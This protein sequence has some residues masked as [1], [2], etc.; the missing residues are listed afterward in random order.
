MFI[1]YLG[2]AGLKP[3]AALS[4]VWCGVVAVMGS[5][6]CLRSVFTR[7][8]SISNSTCLLLSTGILMLKGTKGCLVQ[9]PPHTTPHPP[10][11]TFPPRAVLPVFW[12]LIIPLQLSLLGFLS[13]PSHQFYGIDLDCE[14]LEGMS[15]CLVHPCQSAEHAVGTL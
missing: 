5:Q 9:I 7:N 10:L 15:H 6:E 13:T 4:V 14:Q 3:R 12:N 1:Q 11:P 8:P 2:L